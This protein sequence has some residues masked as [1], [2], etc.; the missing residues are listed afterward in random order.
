MKKLLYIFAFV[1]AIV[2]MACSKSEDSLQEGKGAVTFSFP[3]RAGE[4][5]GE[6]D[7]V[8]EI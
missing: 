4:S 8:S 1:V 2:A 5:S 3:S 6:T 7:G